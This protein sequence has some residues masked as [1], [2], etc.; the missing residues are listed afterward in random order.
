MKANVYISCPISVSSEDFSKVIGLVARMG[1]KPQYWVRGTTYKGHEDIK[2]CDAFVLVTP[3]N[4]FALSLFNISSGCRFEIN[5]ANHNAKRLFLAYT[6]K[7]GLAIYEAKM[8]R[9][10]YEGMP[11]TTN[12]FA[13]HMASSL[14][15]KQNPFEDLRKELEQ[16]LK[17]LGDIREEVSTYNASDLL[18]SI[19]CAKVKESSGKCYP[20]KLK[21]IRIV[22]L[23]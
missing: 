10:R 19:S 8:N 14:E 16:S 17:Y 15:E 6:N 9:V 23:I 13:K 22:L 3:N 11:Y 7:D 1:G 20:K 18:N 4:E 2:T 21:D 12:V 5:L